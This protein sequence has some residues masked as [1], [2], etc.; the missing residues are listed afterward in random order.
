[1]R[2]GTARPSPPARDGGRVGYDCAMA[3][4]AGGIR[5]EVVERQEL[6]D[7][8][9]HLVLE[10]ASG[11]LRLSAT[12]SW[13]LAGEGELALGEGELTLEDDSPPGA[14]R[15]L[16][17]LLESGTLAVDPESGDLRIECLYLVDGVVG[18]WEALG[19]AGRE[20]GRLP[21]RFEVAAAE[22][23]GEVNAPGGG[24]A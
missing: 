18:E 1:M 12:F 19:D 8:T 14:A 24:L 15:E 20:H 3:S 17:A 16:Y 21:C 13:R 2:D 23:L 5:G 22:W 9:V 4:G 7:G 10:G 6:L 11:P